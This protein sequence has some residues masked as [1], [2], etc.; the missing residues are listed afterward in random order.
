MAQLLIISKQTAKPNVQ[1]EG[2]VVGVFSDAHQFSATERE[3]FAIQRIKGSREEV[4]S[5]L[6]ALL[7]KRK[8]AIKWLSD[9]KWHE[10]YDQPF[11]GR[12]LDFAELYEKDG[13]WYRIGVDVKFKANISLLSEL[14]K[15]AFESDGIGTA[16]TTT[17]VEKVVKD[18]SASIDNLEQIVVAPVKK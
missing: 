16:E 3:K 11:D 10:W 5:R 8:D 13:S 15:E 12:V 6:A 14:E 7:P 9:G 18:L 2:D 1:Q 4:A 17:V